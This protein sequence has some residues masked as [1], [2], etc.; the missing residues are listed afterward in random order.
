MKEKKSL[1]DAIK[2]KGKNLEAEMSFF[3]HLE[4]LRWH[5]LRSAVAI[6]IFT[7]LSFVF[8]DFIFDTIIM[9][10]KKPDFWT[11]RMMCKIG[12]YFD[13][14]PDFCIKEIPGKIINTELAGQFTLQLNS[15]LLTGVVLGFPYL[16]WELWRFVKPA[17]HDNERQSASGFVLYAT[18]LFILGIAFGYF[19]VAPLSV[20]FLSNYTVSNVIE[21]TITVDSY[22]STVATLTL[23]TGVVFELPI[24]IYI[25]SKLGI[26]TPQFMRE[27]RRYAIVLILITAAIVTPTPDILTMLTVSFP[28]F[29]LYELSIGVSK[30]V[31]KKKEKEEQEFYSN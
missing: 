11:Y 18:L 22:L 2:Q 26:M 5:L 1:V 27:K 29:M 8:Y 31:Q 13:M 30:N 6:I 19:L 14:G 4:I 16:L 3:D 24:I 15:S 17:L 12:S 10:P 7:I 21:N 28:L 9:G 25:L 23:G 20:N